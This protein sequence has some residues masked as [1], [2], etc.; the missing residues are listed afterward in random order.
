MGILKQTDRYCRAFVA[1][2]EV[3]S[4]IIGVNNP[5]I[6]GSCEPMAC[7]LTPEITVEQLQ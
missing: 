1:F 4:P 7:F 2:Q 6:P 5:A 3:C